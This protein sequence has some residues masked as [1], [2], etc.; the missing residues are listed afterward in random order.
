MH[1][2]H[3]SLQGERNSIH[4]NL[5]FCLFIAEIIFVIGIGRTEQKVKESGCYWTPCIYIKYWYVTNLIHKT[6]CNP[7]IWHS[8]R[9]FPWI[10]WTIL[11]FWQTSAVVHKLLLVTPTFLTSQGRLCCHSASSSLLFS[12][13]LHVDVDGRDSYPR[14]VGASVRRGQIQ[15]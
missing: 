4:K 2:I 6:I 8:I 12:V 15:A 7:L 1:Y 5:V 3:R 11:T 10:I 13:R 9:K 14:H